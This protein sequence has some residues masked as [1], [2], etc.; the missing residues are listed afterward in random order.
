MENGRTGN[1]KFGPGAGILSLVNWPLGNCYVA[2]RLYELCKL[3][4]RY[5]TAVDRERLHSNAADRTFLGVEVGRPHEELAAIDVNG[6]AEFHFGY[7]LLSSSIILTVDAAF[8]VQSPR[9]RRDAARH[10][11]ASSVHWLVSA[12]AR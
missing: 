7:H 2:G 10:L 6:L 3:R 11:T 12:A 8:E 5:R 9:A 1:A 4:N